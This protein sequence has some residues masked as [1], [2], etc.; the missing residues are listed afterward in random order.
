[1]D[2]LI[3]LGAP[4]LAFLAVVALGIPLVSRLADA[5]LRRR[6]FHDTYDPTGRPQFGATSTIEPIDLGPDLLTWP[7]ESSTV[8]PYVEKLAWPSESWD[9]PV[10]GRSAAT[11]AAEAARERAEAARSSAASHRAQALADASQASEARARKPRLKP[12]DASATVPAAGEVTP[13]QPVARP[14]SARRTRSQTV[15]AAVP[16]LLA[17]DADDAFDDEAIRALVRERGLAGAVSELRRRTGRDLDE[18]TRMI[19][20]ARR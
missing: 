5:Q 6:A 7:S 10:F 3:A 16:A 20:D 17:G 2:P 1:M 4:L 18:I 13:P 11:A 19:L 14:A 8:R 9:D 15:P 12:Q